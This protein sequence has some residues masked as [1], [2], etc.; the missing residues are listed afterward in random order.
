MWFQYAQIGRQCINLLKFSQWAQE[1]KYA[2]LHSSIFTLKR[3]EKR[4]GTLQNVATEQNT[5]L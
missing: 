2:S 1:N 4:R 3:I 5:L